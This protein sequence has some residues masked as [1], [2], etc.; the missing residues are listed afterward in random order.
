[1]KKLL[2]API[3]FLLFCGCWRNDDDDNSP[4]PEP[5]VNTCTTNK[6]TCI[7]WSDTKSHG[8]TARKRTYSDRETIT[9]EDDDKWI[10]VTLR[11]PNAGMYDM[12][13][14]TAI[15]VASILYRN[16]SSNILYRSTDGHFTVSQN[17]TAQP[18]TAMCSDVELSS[19]DGVSHSQIQLGEFNNV[20]Y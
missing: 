5:T 1:M 12:I 6:N 3:V 17:A 9:M 15:A 10:Q 11:S 13:D 4:T 16:K 18:I 2:F 8:F 7:R 19:Y 14:D 20:G